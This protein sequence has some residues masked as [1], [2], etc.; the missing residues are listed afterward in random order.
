MINILIL[1]LVVLG[2]LLGSI[3]NIFI[4]KG[5][6]NHALLQLWKSPK[7]W[8]GLIFFVFSTALYLVILPFVELS[9]VYPLSSMTYIWT[10]FLS[11]KFLGEKMNLW[12]WLGLAGIILGIILIGVGS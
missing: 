7:I 1:L 3:G 8:W 4:K 12:K 6:Q 11:L 5:T 9:F 2:S 10:T